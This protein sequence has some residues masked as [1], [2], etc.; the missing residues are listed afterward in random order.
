MAF[1]DGISDWSRAR[2]RLYYGFSILFWCVPLY[3]VFS[4]QRYVGTFMLGCGI[5]LLTFFTGSGLFAFYLLRK[6]TLLEG[7][8][9]FSFE[10]VQLC[11]TLFAGL[12]PFI[13]WSTEQPGN[14]Y[15]RILV[16]I[17]CCLVPV[18]FT[19]ISS[20]IYKATKLLNNKEL[21]SESILIHGINVCLMLPLIALQIF[22]FL[23]LF[24]G[25][26]FGLLF[27]Y[28]AYHQL[29]IRWIFIFILLIPLSLNSIL[30]WKVKHL[31]I[32]QLILGEKV[33]ENNTQLEKVGIEDV[34]IES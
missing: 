14:I 20:I 5:I 26:K 11:L 24:G 18:F 17:L 29:H 2:L 28:L 23:T 15:F 25:P 13:C 21:K 7:V 10:L 12:S 34:V 30:I 33:V 27:S 22:Y 9:S 3:L 19:G 32:T 6:S 16:A 31:I 8:S 1:Q 4:A